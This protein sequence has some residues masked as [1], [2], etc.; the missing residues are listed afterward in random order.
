M[1]DYSNQVQELLN[2]PYR[3]SDVFKLEIAEIDI[4]LNDPRYYE[5][6]LAEYLTTRRQPQDIAKLKEVTHKHAQKYPKPAFSNCFESVL[7]PQVV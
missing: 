7:D 1:K 5:S 2:N 4:I 3:F 6:I